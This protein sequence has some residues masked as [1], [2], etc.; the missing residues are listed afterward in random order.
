MESI[1]LKVKGQSPDGKFMEFIDSQGRVRA[2]IHPPETP[3]PHTVD[4]AVKYPHLHIYDS[5]GN[6]LNKM[7][8][9]VSNKTIDAHIPILKE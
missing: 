9:I 7:L 2:K 5:N 3:K 8:N 4:T 1:G 6:S